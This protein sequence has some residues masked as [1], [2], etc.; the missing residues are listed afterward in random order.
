[1][2]HLRVVL[3]G[4]VSTSKAGMAFSPLGSNG[5]DSAGVL[6]SLGK[7]LQRNVGR[8]PIA[9]VHLVP[10]PTHQISLEGAGNA[11]SS[12]LETA[13]HLIRPNKIGTTRG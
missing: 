10:A 11:R 9:V 2:S 3:Q 13:H 5:Y 8:S 4:E 12:W 7:L 6:N 1:M